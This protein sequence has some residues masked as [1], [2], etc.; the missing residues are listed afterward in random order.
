M[1]L[2]NSDPKSS[3]SDVHSP[4]RPR[5]LII[6]AGAIGDTLMATPLVRAVRRTFPECHLVFLCSA[7][8]LD[9]IRLNPHIDRA[10]T[11][12]RRHLPAWLSSEKRRIH[13]TLRELDLDWA[14]VLESHPSFID[15]ARQGGARRIIAYSG[16]GEGQGFEPARFDPRRHSIENHLD[17]ARP[18][19]LR[20]DGL[21]MELNNQPETIKIV[22]QRL[23]TA[24]VMS[25]DCLVG[26]HAGW[27]GRTRTPDQTRLRSWPPDRFAEVVRWL[28][29]ERG[30]RV[31]LTGSAADRPLTS[32]IARTAGVACLDLAGELS[33]LELA[34][35]I[36]R[37][38]A[39]LTVDSG[40]A[41][42]AA[43]LKTSLVTLWGP[44]IFEQ[45]APISPGNPPRILYRRVHCAPCYGTPAMKTCMDNICMK[46]IEVEDVKG[47][48]EKALKLVRAL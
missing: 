10:I 25:N 33:L 35:L 1:V 2:S 37:M 40:P 43:A 23:K 20:P 14:L 17:L 48:L 44:G 27:G 6:R 30:A 22:A 34:A 41:H 36:R 19:G 28:V 45:T 7:T 12:A 16:N 11:V 18:L 13:H 8:A 21:Q 29:K 31:V 38:N 42:M 39:Y 3:N 15:L 24:G 46:E 4:G 47:A 5:V 26:V 32:Y 9:V